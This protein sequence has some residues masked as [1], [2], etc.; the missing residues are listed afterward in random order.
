MALQVVSSKLFF[1]LYQNNTPAKSWWRPAGPERDERSRARSSS[2]LIALRQE[3]GGSTC[4][5]SCTSPNLLAWHFPPLPSNGAPVVT[6]LPRS[7]RAQA[8]RKT[9]KKTRAQRDTSNIFAMFSESQIQEF[10]E[11]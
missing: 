7:Y 10:K 8:F 6:L 11:V 4:E 3:R 2:L 5:M 9:K 1:I